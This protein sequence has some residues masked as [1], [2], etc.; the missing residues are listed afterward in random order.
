MSAGNLPRKLTAVGVLG[1][2]GAAYTVYEKNWV[3]PECQHENYARREKCFRCR[4]PKI[5]T[6]DALVV[7]SMG[8]QHSWREALDPATNKIYYYNIETN[9]TQW[10]RPAEMGA[11]PHGKAGFFCPSITH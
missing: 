9:K 11:A 7:D 4:A 2:V 1:D 3:C 5:T 8:D 6:A 10:E